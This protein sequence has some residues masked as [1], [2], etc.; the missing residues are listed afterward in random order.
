MYSAQTAIALGGQRLAEQTI[1]GNKSV[2]H[3]VL[4]VL[5][6]CFSK[7]RRDRCALKQAF[8]IGNGWSRCGISVEPYSRFR[9]KCSAR[10]N[11]KRVVRARNYMMDKRIV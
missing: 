7:R 1:R 5:G 11:R 8:M 3:C 2:L 10:G 9:R 6:L 4:M